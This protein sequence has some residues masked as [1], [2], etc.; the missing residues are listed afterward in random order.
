[1]RFGGQDLLADRVE[2]RL[3]GGGAGAGDAGRAGAPVPDLRVGA[4]SCRRRSPSASMRAMPGSQPMRE[5]FA[6]ARDRMTDGLEA[7]RL[8]RSATAPR[9]IS[10]ASTSQASG[11]DARRRERSPNWP[12]SRRASRSCRCRPSPKQD[13]PRHMIRLCFAKRD[14]TIDAGVAAMAKAREYGAMTPAEEARQLL[15][16]LG[17]RGGGIAGKPLADRRAGHRLGRAPPA[18]MMS[19]PPAPMPQ[20]AFLKWRHGAGAAARR[21]G[22]ADRR[23]TARRQ[24]AACPAGDARSRQDRSRRASAKSRR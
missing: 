16:A 15:A 20:D 22:P 8:C 14:E 24:G 2:D 10:C 3:A 6:R 9:P 5:R 18:P 19:R 4:Q 7:G 23:G 12:S 17:V 13:P 21:A 11:I 1:M